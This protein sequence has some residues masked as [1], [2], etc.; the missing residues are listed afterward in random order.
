MGVLVL[1][2]PACIISSFETEKMPFS[3]WHNCITGIGLGKTASAARWLGLHHFHS[4]HKYLWASA[5][6]KEEVGHRFYVISISISVSISDRIISIKTTSTL[7]WLCD[8]RSSSSSS[9][10]SSR[11]NWSCLDKT[12]LPALLLHLSYIIHH[13]FHL[14]SRACQDW[15]LMT[16]PPSWMS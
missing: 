10:S 3:D 1:G 15:Q 7:A 11:V 9:P 16:V 6:C 8:R 5:P 14:S 13:L 12:S 4:R 2:F